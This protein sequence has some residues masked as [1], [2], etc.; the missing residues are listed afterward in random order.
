MFRKAFRGVV[1]PFL[2]PYKDIFEVHK[3]IFEVYKVTIVFINR[4]CIIK[5]LKERVFEWQMK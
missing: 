3:D 5:T 1:T 2:A 4:T